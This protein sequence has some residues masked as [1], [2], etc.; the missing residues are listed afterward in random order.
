MYL[1]VCLA[2]AGCVLLR[3]KNESEELCI[4]KWHYGALEFAVAVG[5]SVEQTSKQ[6]VQLADKNQW[7][8]M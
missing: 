5:I 6:G 2:Q 8:R 7:S 3:P 1:V 4:K